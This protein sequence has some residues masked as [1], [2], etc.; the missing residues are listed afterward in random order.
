MIFGH[1]LY[2]QCLTPYKGLT[3]K[4]LY[5]TVEPEWFKL[6]YREACLSLD[7]Q[8]AKWLGVLLRTPAQLLPLPV[9]GVPLWHADNA[10]ESF[11][12]DRSYFR[13]AKR[14]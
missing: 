2:Q 14:Y 5:L 1:G 11:Y 10:D 6:G 9:L 8:L 7:R 4:A 13:A 12:N 3:G